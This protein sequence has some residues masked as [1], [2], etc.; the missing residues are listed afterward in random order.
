MTSI[1]GHRWTSFAGDDPRSFVG[2][3]WSSDLLHFTRGEI[4]AAFDVCKRSID[5]WPPSLIGFKKMCYGIPSFNKLKA[6][7]GNRK[8]PFSRLAWSV[9]DPSMRTA[10]TNSD[11]KTAE[12]LLMWVYEKCVE[13]RMAGEPFPPEPAALLESEKK[14]INPVSRDVALL[15]IYNSLSQLNARDD[16]LYTGYPSDQEN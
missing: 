7:I 11:T 3:E 10:F 14:K 8:N 13:L 9:M 12:K 4:D 6:E 5:E 16:D 2:R 1:Y 15:H